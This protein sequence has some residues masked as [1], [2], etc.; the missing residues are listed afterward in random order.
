MNLYFAVLHPQG[1]VAGSNV[2]CAGTV[3]ARDDFVCLLSCQ[4]GQSAAGANATITLPPP[5]V[6]NPPYAINN[7][8]TQ[9]D[10]S[11]KVRVCQSW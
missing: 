1:N 9:L 10:L 5:G 7:N 4:T 6:F 8:G 3:D 11:A 2:T